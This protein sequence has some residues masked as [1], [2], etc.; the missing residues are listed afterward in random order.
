[1]LIKYPYVVMQHDQ[2]NTP[3]PDVNANR[4]RNNIWSYDTP[5]VVTSHG[6]YG[7]DSFFRAVKIQIRIGRR[8]SQQCWGV[9]AGNAR[10]NSSNV[11]GVKA[12]KMGRNS[13]GYNSTSMIRRRG[14]SYLLL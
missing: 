10:H 13:S 4:F 11:R 5:I 14:V 7:N 1:M 8:A 12:G 2:P 3:L 9:T 6:C